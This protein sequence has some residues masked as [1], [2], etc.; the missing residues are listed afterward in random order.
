MR[1]E[2][3]GSVADVQLVFEK[4]KLEKCSCVVIMDEKAALSLHCNYS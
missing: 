2:L 4:V 1:L 3:V